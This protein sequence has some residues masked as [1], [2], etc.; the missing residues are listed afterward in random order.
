MP[1]NKSLSK[2]VFGGSWQE[3]LFDPGVVL[4]S[5]RQEDIPMF[6]KE[7]MLR[8]ERDPVSSTF[9]FR[10]IITELFRS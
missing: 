1:S 8:N 2:L 6:S 10:D 7:L 4:F 5:I 9:T 3:I